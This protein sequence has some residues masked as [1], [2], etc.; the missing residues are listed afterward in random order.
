M[1]Q[2]IIVDVDTGVDDSLALLY[3]LA[4][5]EA[6][7]VGIVSTAGNVGAAQVAVNNLAWLELCRAPEIEVALGSAEPLVIAL[8][9][10]EDTHGPQGVGY[11]ELPAPNRQVS[12]RNAPDLWVELARE[13]P[14]EIVG[15]CTGPLTN[16]ALAL[17]REPALPQL[18]RRLV[19]MG[20]AFN[21]PGNT[22]PTNE[23][24]VHVDPE[25]AKEVFDAF[26]AAPPDRRP[27]ICA[28]DITESIEMRPE[29]LTRLAERAGSVPAELVSPADPP[30]A[31]SVTSNPIIRHLT[32]A[33]RFYFD[34]HQSY[35]LGYLAHMHDPFAAAVALDPALARTR[36][37]TVDVELTGTLTRATTVADWAG[38]WGREPNADIVVG[39]DPELF[40]DR[41]ISRVG[42]FAA[43]VYPPG[44]GLIPANAQ[45]AP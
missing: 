25:A 14:G 1:R 15:L 17:R 39:T 32:D 7:I 6:E 9:T 43:A 31:R 35:D 33:V 19:V 36:P 18:L 22:T 41:L 3:L 2:K 37:A 38:M 13:H 28:L 26:S 45:E 10:T 12:D 29:H 44:A 8:R 20:G 24:N 21:H 34:F 16:L 30:G 42:D 23:W 11:A 40:F 4:S 5:P 27:L